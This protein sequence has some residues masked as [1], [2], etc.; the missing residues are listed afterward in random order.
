MASSILVS[1]AATAASKNTVGR[2]QSPP[3][4][5]LAPIWGLPTSSEGI[6]HSLTRRLAANFPRGG[7]SKEEENEGDEYDDEDEADQVE[8]V[9]AVLDDDD[10]DEESE[11]EDGAEMDGVQIELINVEKKYDD[12]I[13]A[14]PMSNLYASLGV[15][16][17]ARKVDLFHPTVVRI[18]RFAFISYL[19]LHQLFL[20]YVRI[21]A[22]RN[23]DRTPIE[24][25]N[26]LS[27]MLQN[28]LGGLESGGNSMM[29]NMA[30]SFLSS[31]STVLEYDLKQTRGM[32]SGLIFNMLLMWFLHF[33]MAQVQPL[34]I[35]TAN[36][37]MA[38][39]YSPLFQIYVLGRNL[40][41]PF[42]N[43]TMKKLED[44]TA[45]QSATAVDVEDSA[46]AASADEEEEEGSDEDVD[47]SIMGDEIGAKS[48]EVTAVTDDDVEAAEKSIEGEAFDD[49]E[50]DDD[51]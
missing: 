42:K 8:V 50:D 20:F 31:K 13:V 40:E 4:E 38:L 34:L 1:N 28:Q 27:S 51:E 43:P 32:Q 47:S 33:K 41:R 14:S 25:K 7:S 11:C 39:V 5:P 44:M 17:L 3:L 45:A 6:G 23:N 2:H 49:E 15:M 35:Q 21:Q 26:P 48:N 24:L 16:L 36:G 18:A 9:E 46:V 12:P 37:L 10:D 30:S 22:K 29:K 19:V